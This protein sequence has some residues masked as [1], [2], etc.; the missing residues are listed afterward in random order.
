MENK[1]VIFVSDGQDAN[2]PNKH[3]KL[4]NKL[5]DDQLVDCCL[6]SNLTT[7]SKDPKKHQLLI[8]VVDNRLAISRWGLPSMNPLIVDFVSMVE[9]IRTQTH[10]LQS[11]LLIKACGLNKKSNQTVLDATAG[12]G[13]DAFLLHSTGA[14]VSMVEFHPLLYSLLNDGVNNYLEYLPQE[15]DFTVTYADS[16]NYMLDASNEKR[17][18]VYLDPMFAT[19]NK[20]ALV[21]REMQLIQLVHSHLPYTSD[22][23]Q[24]LSAAKGFAKSRVV[25]KRAINASFLD[26][27]QPNYSLKGKAIRFDVYLT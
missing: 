3:F 6:K 13:T 2:Q 19:K 17:D 23:A 10:Q 14:I 24:L 1:F 11:E 9:K 20:N 5:V 22:Q 18:I 7:P 25:V 4:I 12:I 26:Q 27:Q 15:N 8:E 21:K 16:C